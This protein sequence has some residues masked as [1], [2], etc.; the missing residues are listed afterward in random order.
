[1]GHQTEYY[2]QK[3]KFL[4]HN[5]ISQGF[6][7]SRNA[8]TTP[9]NQSMRLVLLL[10][11]KRKHSQTSSSSS[12]KKQFF[13]TVYVIGIT[14]FCE[15]FYCMWWLEKIIFYK[16]LSATTL[17]WKKSVFYVIATRILLI[18]KLQNETVLDYASLSR[19]LTFQK[20]LL[21]SFNE[22]S[23]K[24]MKIAFCFILNAIFVLNIFKF[25]SSP[26]F[27]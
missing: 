24:V 7:F 18:S 15:C 22:S 19:T 6:L 8:K 25:F 20:I 17:F 5:L 4:A 16:S 23:L 27:M 26:L 3:T 10:C 1:M 14:C 13:F 9:S 21:I 2:I 11:L 12:C